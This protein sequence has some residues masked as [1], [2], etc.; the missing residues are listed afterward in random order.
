MV[1]E[2]LHQVS[3]AVG[4]NDSHGVDFLP[5]TSGLVVR[6]GLPACQLVD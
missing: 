1:P 2:D 5:E 6:R 3:F 4:Q